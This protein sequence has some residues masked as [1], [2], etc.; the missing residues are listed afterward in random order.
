[1]VPGSGR[2]LTVSRV[3]VKPAGCPA[4][5]GGWC[6]ENEAFLVQYLGEIRR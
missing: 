4:G 2:D 5:Q 1:M 6:M 3:D